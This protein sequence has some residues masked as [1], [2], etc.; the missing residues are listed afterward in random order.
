V[1][2][3]MIVRNQRPQKQSEKGQAD[4]C[5]GQAEGAYPPSLPGT[6]FSPWRNVV[7]AW[8]AHRRRAGG[9]RWAV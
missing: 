3:K 8:F 4:S 2:D 6:S 1:S 5:C 9:S 7:C